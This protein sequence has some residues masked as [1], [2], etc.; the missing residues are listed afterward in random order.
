MSGTRKLIVVE[1]IPRTGKKEFSRL[2]ATRLQYN[3]I[4]EPKP[5]S[6]IL[7]S[8]YRTGERYTLATELYFLVSRYKHL[9]QAMERDLFSPSESILSFMMEKSRIYASMTLSEEEQRIYDSIYAMLGKTGIEP[10]L[11]VYLYADPSVILKRVRS[12]PIT[13]EEFM[14]REYIESLTEAYH[15][16]FYRFTTCPVVFFDVSD[17]PDWSVHGEAVVDDLVRYAEQVKPGANFYVPR[18]SP[19]TGV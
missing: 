7:K 11:V 5:D 12:N 16:F 6:G 19:H 17:Y 14:T 1:G 2:L 13:G 10:D 9:S 3:L 18:I 4:E 15:S 8:F